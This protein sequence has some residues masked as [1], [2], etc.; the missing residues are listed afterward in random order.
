MHGKE[1]DVAKRKV[2]A[3]P[4]KSD[5]VSVDCPLHDEPTE[6]KVVFDAKP[7]N[8]AQKGA[9]RVVKCNECGLVFFNPNMSPEARRAYHGEEYYVQ[10][11]RGCIGYPNYLEDDHVNAKL[12]FGKLILSWCK[13][14]FPNK[15]RKPGSIIDFGC[16]T[17]HMGVPFKEASWRVVGVE[18]SEWAVNWGKEN[19]GLDLRCQDMDDLRLEED[20]KFDVV[21]F[22]DSLEHSQRP[23]ELLR[24]VYAHSPEDMLMIIQLPDVGAYLKDPSHQ[25]WSLYQHCFHYIP[26]T[27]RLLLEMEGFKVQRKM[28]SSQAGEMLFAAVKA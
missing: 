4:A 13:R 17:G 20:E 1:F 24:K 8:W 21:M 3:A 12:Y 7:N 15:K 5:F 18:F 27:L 19:L 9:L 2:R 6:V 28:P 11:D 10:D 22:W 16:A 14:L 23:R 26:E 25:F